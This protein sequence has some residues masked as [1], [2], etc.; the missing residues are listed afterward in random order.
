MTRTECDVPATVQ[1]LR[2]GAPLVL[3]VAACDAGALP[4]ILAD[5]G[6]ERP[7]IE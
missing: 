1:R 6:P 4:G 3:D 7:G 5:N 2:P